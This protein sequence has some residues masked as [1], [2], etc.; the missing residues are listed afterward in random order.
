MA[1][2]A[3]WKNRHISAA[4]SAI[5]TTFGMVKQSESLDRSDRYKF[6]VNGSRDISAT[7]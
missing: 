4:V 2:A 1:A 6:E 3:I 5:S 7:V